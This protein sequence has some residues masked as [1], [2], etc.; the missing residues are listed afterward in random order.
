MLLD[1]LALVR[2]GLEGGLVE[3][4]FLLPDSH[5]ELAALAQKGGVP[6]TSAAEEILRKLTQ[7]ERSPG[8]AAVARIP[9][10]EELEPLLATGDGLVVFLDGVSDPGNVGAIARSAAAFGCR[11]LLL[12][13]GC[14]DAWA[15]KT[16]RASAGA[17]LRIAVRK[18]PG[19]EELASLD[20]IVL[21]RAVAHGGLNPDEVP[22]DGR[23][24][25]WL[26]NE[27]HGPGT[28]P[29]GAPVRDIT[30]PI[31]GEVESLNVAAAAAVLCWELTSSARR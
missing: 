4:L 26:G 12:G 18:L 8:A 28:A 19:L 24:V 5:P 2:E 21:L 3:E 17:L 22:T 13:P 11:G 30:L 15:P 9:E 16:L 6:V 1:S 27:A 20:G 10:D 25:L 7:V 14:A 31:Q 29:D 23:R